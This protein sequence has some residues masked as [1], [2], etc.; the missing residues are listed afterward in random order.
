[1]SLS[2][3]DPHL[4]APKRLAALGILSA[5]KR[6]EF[7][8]VRDQLQLSNSDLS[9]QLKV[10]LDPKDQ[11]NVEAKLDTFANIYTSITKKQI[12]FEFYAERD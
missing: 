3:L 9:K 10:L 1:M 2:D 12:V 4:T 7:G 6:V 5:T 11:V 8:Y